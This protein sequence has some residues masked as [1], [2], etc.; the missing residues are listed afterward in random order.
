MTD[1]DQKNG[2][3]PE[4]EKGGPGSDPEETLRDPTAEELTDDDVLK[5]LF[6]PETVEIVGDSD[7]EDSDSS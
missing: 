5:R 4:N 3:D 2:S 6:P 7:S 1:S